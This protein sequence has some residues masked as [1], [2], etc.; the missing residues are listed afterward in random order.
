MVRGGWQDCAVEYEPQA[1]AVQDETGRR[2]GLRQMK[3]RA[4]GLLVFAALVYVAVRLFGGD[5]DWTGYVEA[6]AEGSMVGGL[7]DWFAVTALF[8]HP[9]G[10]PIPHTALI[11]TRK[12]QLGRAIG[13]F[14]EEN[15]LSGGVVLERLRAVGVARRAA[16]WV[17]ADEHATTVAR[18]SS[19]ALAGAAGVL[20]DETVQAAI[21]H[22][23]VGWVRR[24]PIAPLAGRALTIA[25]SQG[26]HVELVDAA[27]LGGLRFMDDHRE[28]LRS[29]FGKESPWWVPES[30]DDRIFTKLFDGLRGFLAE[31]GETP[32]HEFRQYLEDRVAQLAERLQNDPDLIARGEEL[33]N[34]ILSHPAVQRWT[35]SLWTDLKS[36]LQR[37]ADDPSSELRH[38][39]AVEIQA[40]GR[41]VSDDP[42][43]QHKVDRWV[44]SV[45]T[46]LLEEHRN[47][48][49]DLIASTV[50]RWN[51]QDASRR[52]EL[53]V[54]RDLQFIRINGTVVGGLAGVAIYAVGRLI[55]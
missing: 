20:R 4:T 7:A 6:A 28:L 22:S 16:A 49:G 54:G 15:F 40:I 25:T 55:S 47:Q 31:V 1:L 21:E 51:P 17:S 48:A 38:R 46:Y 41:R 12:D 53:A 5:G 26:R 43:L 30:I 24:V 37:Q 35:A 32:H 52:V 8:R 23:I 10:I 33:K 9:M 19:A 13:G 42:Q 18:H 2:G 44:E 34:E 36:L 3:A 14:V 27:L 11:P 45:V 50:A 29:R 39:I